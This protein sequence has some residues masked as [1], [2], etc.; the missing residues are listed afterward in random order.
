MMT[1]TTGARPVRR[2]VLAGLA[3]LVLL[4]GGPSRGQEAGIDR[5][6]A[7]GPDPL[8]VEESNDSVDEIV[9]TA[10]KR[11]ESLQDVPLSIA[12]FSSQQ[13]I[14]Q[15]LRNSRD[16]ANFTV[17][18][19]TLEQT[20]RDID[21]PIIR[22]M[23]APS[24]RGEPNASYFIDGVFV[25]GSISTA[26]TS[27]LQRV[28]ILRGPQSAQF[29]RATFSGAV[30]YVTKNPTDDYE[31]QVNA[32]AG[33]SDDYDVGAWASGPLVGDQLYFVLSGDWSKYGGQWNNTLAEGQA[34]YQNAPPNL[35][36][37][38]F[39]FDPPQQ[40]DY[41]RLGGEETTD[42]MAKLVWRP[43]DGA[44]VSLKYNYTDS[45]DDHFPSLIA[46]DLNCFLPSAATRDETWYAS[47]QGY[48][49]GEWDAAGKVNRIN[50]PDLRQGVTYF[51]APDLPNPED[52]SIPGTEP[53]TFRTQNR[54]FLAYVQDIADYTLTFRGAYNKDDFRQLFDLDHTEFRT[55]WGLFH[56]D[57]LRDIEDYS[58]E[59]RLDTPGDLPVRGSVGAYWYS[60]DR[61]N[62]QRSYVGPQV[63][64]GLGS[65]TTAYPPSVFIDITN[66]AVFGSIDVDFNDQWTLILEGRYGEDDKALSGGSLTGSCVRNGQAVPG[67]V[68]DQFDNFTPR[69]TLRYSPDPDLMAY[70]LAAKGNKPGDFNTEFFRAGIDPCAVLAG[71]N[72]VA[73][74]PVYGESPPLIIPDFP[75]PAAIV[76]EEEQ[77]TYEI[78]GKFTWL[79]GRLL[80]NLALYY[81]D[82]TNQG[83]FTTVQILQDTGTYLTTTILQNVGKS[84]VKGLE[85]ES[86]LL[87]NDYLSLTLNYGYTDSQYVEGYDPTQ[88][89]TTGNGDLSGNYV[90]SVPRHTVIFGAN[91]TR[92]INADLSLFVRP[93][94]SYNSKRY[95][96][97]NN[98]AYIGNDMTLNLRMGVE[99]ERWT[100]T[101][102]VTNLLDDDT[103]LAALDF[104]NFGPV[105]ANYPL[106]TTNP[107]Q[108]CQN[109]LENCQYPLLFS[110][111]PKRGRDWGVEL[112][113][114]F[115]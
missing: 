8:A 75:G 52:F 61:T 44:E 72:G 99:S 66:T 81:I 17:G 64:F 92:P 40:A 50:L 56:F 35:P 109:L 112:Q 106:D 100:V 71:I 43:T 4:A 41:S 78:G 86:S 48:Y 18:Y 14:E 82:W 98:L 3:A 80:T 76:D 51:L 36:L 53:G 115:R 9:V 38:R 105:P 27:S 57:N 19:R 83:L 7:G 29:G 13:L 114:R 16:I 97:A 15:G 5:A 2:L 69:I 74:D 10:R 68:S 49:C 96:S 70:I 79:D 45:E 91:A 111:N 87:V 25:S 32:R 93:D 26:V 85:F 90:P 113:Y 62:T 103:P 89:A 39:L 37:K 1:G 60:Q 107:N 30:N 63:A 31:G 94:L 108:S 54:L 104:V 33:T 28:E 22:G 12:T 65:V 6:P 55:L 59:L 95:T 11:E 101:G 47:T 102:Y 84:E 24:T 67:E 73:S 21:R 34:A 77:W 42:V 20:G 110:L 23:A 88:A 58:A 46:A